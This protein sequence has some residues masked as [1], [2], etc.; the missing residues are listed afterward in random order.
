M[1]EEFKPG[2]VSE[3][4]SLDWS[5]DGSTI[6]EGLLNGDI[7]LWDADSGRSLNRITR[8]T[9]RRADVNG[10]AWSQDGERLASAHQDGRIRLWNPESGEL[11]LE[12][13]GHGGW[14]RGVAW[15]PD[16]DMLA[17]TGSDGK[18]ILWD[19]QSGESVARF[20]GSSH[21]I[22]SVDWSPDGGYLAAGNGVYDNQSVNG[23]IFVIEAPAYP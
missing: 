18:V 13:N 2:N 20:W 7:L 8:Y 5:P 3:A 16:G 11:V 15:S 4:I 12:M 14:A 19:P 22:W 9:T 21:P 6:A 17:T 1:I 10:L 23:Q